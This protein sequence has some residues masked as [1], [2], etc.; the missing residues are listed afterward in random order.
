[1]FHLRCSYGKHSGTSCR[2]MLLGFLQPPETNTGLHNKVKFL[3][4]SF[5]NSGLVQ[6]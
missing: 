5:T 4:S 3:R 2:S 1:M 6:I